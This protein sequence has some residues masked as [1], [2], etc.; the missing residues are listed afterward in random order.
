R[1]QLGHDMARPTIQIGDEVREMTKAEHEQWLLDVEQAEQRRNDNAA[2][3]AAL[4]SAR[5][6]LAKLGLTDDELE[7]FLGV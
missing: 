3:L 6:K 2:K 1:Q 7:A 4:E 5:A